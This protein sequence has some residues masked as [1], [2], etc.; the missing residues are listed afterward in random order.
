[1]PLIVQAM[2]AQCGKQPC[3]DFQIDYTVELSVE[4]MK[5][6]LEAN[7]WIVQIN[8]KHFDIYCSKQCAK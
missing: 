2:C 6:R 4:E 1:M 3:K 5:R 7:N 8:G